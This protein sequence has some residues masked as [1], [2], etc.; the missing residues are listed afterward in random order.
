MFLVQ[1]VGDM[2]ISVLQHCR[3]GP[4]VL[5]DPRSHVQH[6]TLIGRNSLQ[7]QQAYRPWIIAERI[8]CDQGGKGGLECNIKEG[9]YRS[10]VCQTINYGVSALQQEAHV[11]Q[12]LD[13]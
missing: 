5:Y 1:E 2:S 7:L 4:P 6:V 13:D 8:R 12:P 3:H 10:L 9:W 11:L